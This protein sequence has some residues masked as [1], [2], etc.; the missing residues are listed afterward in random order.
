V[1]KLDLSLLWARELEARGFVGYGREEWRGEELHT[2]DV[3][4]RLLMEGGLPVERMVTH[5]FPLRQY[6]AA[7]SAAANRRRSEAVKVVLVP[8]EGL[9]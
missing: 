2:F 8:G 3:T 6:R 5:V 1:K 4:M 9:E 7:L